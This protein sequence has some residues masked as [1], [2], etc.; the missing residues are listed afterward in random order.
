MPG[1]ESFVCHAGW[2]GFSLEIDGEPQK[3][4]E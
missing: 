1:K 4:F 2:L 3:G